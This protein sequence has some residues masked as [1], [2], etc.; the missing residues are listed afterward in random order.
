[1]H[2]S[3]GVLSNKAIVSISVNAWISPHVAH[4]VSLTDVF[5]AGVQHMKDNRKMIVRYVQLY[6]RGRYRSSDVVSSPDVWFVKLSCRDAAEGEDGW[7]RFE[8]IARAAMAEVE[9]MGQI[10]YIPPR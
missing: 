2:V 7:A 10:E 9:G 8:E 4:S 3:F 5:E 1:M 6:P